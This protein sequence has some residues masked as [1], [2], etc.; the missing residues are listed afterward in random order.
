[1]KKKIF[2][3]RLDPQLSEQLTNAAFATKKSKHQYCLDVIRREAEKD[4]VKII[5]VGHKIKSDL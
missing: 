4:C 5:R 2:P 3:L 1:M